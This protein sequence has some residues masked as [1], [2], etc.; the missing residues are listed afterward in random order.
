MQA[1]PDHRR[2]YTKDGEPY[3]AGEIL[4]QP[5]YAATLELLA[6]DGPDAFYRGEIA[7]R[8]VADFAAHGGFISS[9][10][11]ATYQ[12]DETE[13]LRTSYRGLEMV[14]AGPPA[15]GVTLGQ[16]LNFLEGFDL[17]GL[18]WPSL[19]AAELMVAAMGW[20]FAD[21]QAWLADPKFAQVPVGRML[22][23]AYA[24]EARARHQSGRLVAAA[25]P[26]D[27]PTTTHVSVVDAAGD[28]VS[29]THTLGYSSGVVTPGLGFPYNNYLNCFDPR[30]GGAN[31]LA[32]GKTR[33]TMMTP[34]L[35]FEDGRLGIV[36]GAP[37]GTRIVTGVLQALLNLIDHGMDPVA[38]V[39][40]P[41]IDF[42]GVHVSAENRIPAW[43]LEGLAARG[44][45]VVRRPYNYDPYFSRVQVIR[46]GPDG[47]LEGASDP[48]GD[49]G[50]A[51]PA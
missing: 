22:D 38:A 12:V 49:G 24:E 45:Q 47:S 8:I 6:R 40:A 15:G 32:P 11:L 2:I 50:V 36:I 16:M 5:E 46:V 25:P 1:S 31:S 23:K 20:A 44:H 33:V 35:A 9:R 43:V 19:P 41:R 39:S 3:A 34:A 17:S 51:L 30:P 26:P 4:V 37:G 14:L 21:R 13:P 10:D 7:Q 27:P 48:R 18:G 28:A 29:M 42:Q